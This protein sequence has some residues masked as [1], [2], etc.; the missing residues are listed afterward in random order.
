MEEV[1]GIEYET[2]RTGR[3]GFKIHILEDY[4]IK[5]MQIDEF[6]LGLCLSIKMWTDGKT[7]ENIYN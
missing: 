1:I 6:I 5:S 7:W 3:S 2:L 4:H